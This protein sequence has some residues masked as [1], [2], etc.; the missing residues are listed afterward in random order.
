VTDLDEKTLFGEEAEAEKAPWP[1]GYGNLP[2]VIEYTLF[3]Q[4]SL[5]LTVP[6]PEG[7]GPSP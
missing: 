5:W 2:P 1:H 6:W 7:Y 3:G 4:E